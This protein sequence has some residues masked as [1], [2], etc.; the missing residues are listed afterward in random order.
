MLDDSAP[1]PPPTDEFSK[2]MKQALFFREQANPDLPE[3]VK[4][5]CAP[6]VAARF[7]NNDMI[8]AVWFFPDGTPRYNPDGTPISADQQ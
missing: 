8:A 2:S 1:P 7:H 4:R 6:E 3:G 5:R